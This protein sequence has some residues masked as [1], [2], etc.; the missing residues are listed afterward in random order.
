MQPVA[1]QPVYLYLITILGLEN[2]IYEEEKKEYTT[3]FDKKRIGNYC[4]AQG[5]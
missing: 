5:E 4:S 3:G 1:C 2:S